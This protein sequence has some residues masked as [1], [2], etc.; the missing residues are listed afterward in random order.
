MNYC[1]TQGWLCN[2]V[3]DTLILDTQT[4]IFKANVVHITICCTESFSP[5]FSTQELSTGKTK[6]A[7]QTFMDTP[8][9]LSLSSEFLNIYLCYKF[10]LQYSQ[11]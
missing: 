10:R 4:P 3:L 6:Q 9:E 11:I 5:V 8:P 7:R 1:Q 2:C